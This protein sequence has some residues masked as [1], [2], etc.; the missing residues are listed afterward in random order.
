MFKYI[1]GYTLPYDD[2]IEMQ[3]CLKD[4]AQDLAE[5]NANEATWHSFDIIAKYFDVD[6]SKQVKK[7]DYFDLTKSLIM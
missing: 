5:S 6:Y 3:E 1:D 2:Y 4:L 7:I